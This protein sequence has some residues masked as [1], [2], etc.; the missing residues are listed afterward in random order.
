MGGKNFEYGALRGEEALRAWI[1]DHPAPPL[2][3]EQKQ[4]FARI[5]T[6]A[7]GVK[8]DSRGQRAYRET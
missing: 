6:N 2:S 5:F 1:G 3:E 4:H 7:P 8:N